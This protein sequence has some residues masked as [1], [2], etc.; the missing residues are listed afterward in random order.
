MTKQADTT[1]GTHL[2]PTVEAGVVN[3]LQQDC[4]QNATNHGFK[5]D[6][7]S[8]G[9]L[10]ELADKGADGRRDTRR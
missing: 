9:W 5:Q 3:A 6:W 1:N 7:E 10:E 2:N 4:H 8:A